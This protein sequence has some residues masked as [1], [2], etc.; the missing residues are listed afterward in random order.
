MANEKTAST[1]FMSDLRGE[2]PGGEVLKHADTAMIGLP[3]CSV[4]YNTHVAW[5]EFKFDFLDD[6]IEDLLAD[7]D[8]TFLATFLLGRHRKT[9]ETQYQKVC[10]LGR[11]SLGLYVF[12]VHK[13]CVVVLEPI[14][15][16]C[17]KMK[18]AAEAASFVGK[19]MRGWR[20]YDSPFGAYCS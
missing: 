16:A 12:F 7:G 20:A 11:Q 8:P 6:R 5:L 19:V 2:L 1:Q 9:A 3:D 4:T 15:G 18:D 13:T 10:S 14:T 17:R